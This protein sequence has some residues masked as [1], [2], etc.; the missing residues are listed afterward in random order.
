M[1]DLIRAQAA[2]ELPQHPIFAVGDQVRV[3]SDSRAGRKAPHTG[4]VGTVLAVCPKCAAQIVYHNCWEL[5][6]LLD[7]G[8]Q[9]DGPGGRDTWA[10]ADGDVQAVDLP[11]RKGRRKK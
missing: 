5:V 10:Y 4:D 2:A 9:E 7:F 8:P 3:I 6:Y 1:L 11:W